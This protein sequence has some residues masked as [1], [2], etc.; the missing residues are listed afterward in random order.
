MEAKKR[1]IPPRSFFEHNEGSSACQSMDRRWLM[2][3]WGLLLYCRA[4]VLRYIRASPSPSCVTEHSC[5][6]S[7]WVR[8][9]SYQSYG[10]GY[11]E[12]TSR[13][14][15]ESVSQS[16][17]PDVGGVRYEGMHEFI[18]HVSCSL[19]PSIHARSLLCF[20]LLCLLLRRALLVTRRGHCSLRFLYI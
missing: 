9:V 3:A 15:A 11:Y 1:A 8:E 16:L 2:M 5:S 17:R 20:L 7:S 10:G 18:L 12:D 14:C 6:Q 4:L 19:L 13:S